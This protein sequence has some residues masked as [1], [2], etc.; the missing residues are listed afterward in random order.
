MGNLTAKPLFVHEEIILATLLID[1]FSAQKN[2][3]HA[4]ELG[5]TVTGT[6]LCQLTIGDFIE[7]VAARKSF[8]EIKNK[9]DQLFKLAERLEKSAV[10]TSM[11][12][13]YV[14]KQYLHIPV[15]TKQ[16]HRTHTC[17]I[18]A[19]LGNN[20]LYEAIKN[21]V[22]AVIG[23]DEK[24]DPSMGSGILLSSN[25]I[26]TC[27]H[28]ISDMKVTHVE[29]YN[30]GIFHIESEH[31]C[32]SIDVGILF[33]KERLSNFNPIVFKNPVVL[34]DVITVGYPPVPMAASNF[35]VVQ[36]GEV[37]TSQL[38]T[39]DNREVFLFSAVARPGNSG[40]PV[41]A[42]DGTFCGI[43]TREL[44]KADVSAMPHFAG[45][46]THVIDRALKELNLT[47][48]LP[49]ETYD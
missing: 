3:E 46:P 2:G 34:D 14:G 36:K 15:R 29:D 30:G 43:V 27:E 7:W 10:L 8:D 20:H 28:V 47:V 37:V 49:I 45:V 22:V 18:S 44:S 31:V 4:K 13:V 24:G 5:K 16:Q 12:G 39:Y 25:A 11:G 35:Q 42:L 9:Q 1:F 41:I 26:L 40:G 32:D 48:Q 33:T 19:K 38:T 17:W 23:V 6:T 21:N